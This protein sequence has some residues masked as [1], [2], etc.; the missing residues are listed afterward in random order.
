[1]WDF[2]VRYLMRPLRLSEGEMAELADFLEN[3]VEEKTLFH[4]VK[5]KVVPWASAIVYFFSCLHLS[6]RQRP[7]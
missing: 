4:E 5:G 2:I 7:F 6:G 3:F 1:M